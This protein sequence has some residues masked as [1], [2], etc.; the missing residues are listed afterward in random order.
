MNLS[1]IT[2]GRV[3]KNFNHRSKVKEFSNHLELLVEAAYDQG[4]RDCTESLQRV[5]LVKIEAQDGTEW[6]LRLGGTIL[7]DIPD[8]VILELAKQARR[9]NGE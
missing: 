5:D 7:L 9:P 6:N 1:N 3:G 8:H 2:F 4:V